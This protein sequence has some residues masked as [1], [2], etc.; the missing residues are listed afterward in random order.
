M[1]NSNEYKNN[2]D[3]LEE[4]LLKSRYSVRDPKTGKPLE[5]CYRDLLTNRLFSTLNDTLIASKEELFELYD[6]MLKRIIIPASPILM[7]L[8]NPHTRRHG[9]YSCYPLGYVQ[10]DM[11]SIEEIHRLMR[12]IYMSGG[13]VGIDLSKLRPMGSLVDNGQGI[14]SGPVGFLADFDAVT[15]TT[16]QGGRRRGALLVQMD[17]NHP[18]IKEFIKV[19]NI[20][21]KLNQYINTLP[22]D[23]RPVQGLQLSNMNI[24]V[25]AFGDFWND[26]NLI[27]LIA[28]NMWSTGDPGLLFIDNMLKNSPI[29]EEDNPRF[30]NPCVT[31]DTLVLTNKGQI[32]IIDLLDTPTV[33]WNGY[34]WSEVIPKQ[35]GSKQAILKIGF[36]NGAILKCTKYHKFPI[37]NNNIVVM[38]EAQNLSLGDKLKKFNYPVIYQESSQY[39]NFKDLYTRDAGM[40]V[41]ISFIEELSEVQDVYCFN[42]PKRHLGVFNGILTGQCGEFLSSANTACNLVTVN[43]GKIATHVFYG[44]K[45][46]ES[47]THHTLLDSYQSKVFRAGQLAAL[48]GNI[49]LAR[50]E[51]FPSPEIKEKTQQMRPVGVGMTGFHSALIAYDKGYSQ[52]GDLKSRNFAEI[53]QASLTLGTLFTSAKLAHKY[54]TGYEN[55]DY[56]RP[57]VKSLHDVYFSMGSPYNPLLDY[58]NRAVD[59][60]G[61]FYNC[62]TTSQPPTGSVSIF[63]HNMDTGIEPFFA[64][65]QERKIRDPEKGWVSFKQVSVPLEEQFAKDPGLRER[66]ESQTA[67]NLSPEA[68]LDMLASFQKYIHTGVSK[69]IN[70][71]AS[72]TVETIKQLILKAKDMNLKGFTVYRDTSLDGVLTAVSPPVSTPKNDESAPISSAQESQSKTTALFQNMD[73]ERDAVI[74]KAKSTSLNAHITLSHD[75][76]QNIREVFVAAGDLG[77][78]V[79][80]LFTAFGMIISVALRRSPEIFD[81]LVKVLCKV[82]M[83]QR[84]IIKTKMS[85]TPIVGNSLPQAIGLLMRLRKDFLT[86]GVPVPVSHALGGFDICPECQK[87]TLRREGSCK[88]CVEC[89]YSTC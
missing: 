36:S 81:D 56:W 69:T 52:Y 31:G 28:Q 41:T 15:G 33:V 10:D 42:E 4:Y 32:P 60:Y 55:E 49:I 58:I 29:K 13:G 51:G 57:H 61:G 43:V 22:V 39:E 35:T 34:E 3:I 6:L 53:T 76:S 68:Q 7:S 50:D 14:S 5:T 72:A 59:E 1:D 48:L 38:T 16:N 17:W 71:P 45:E 19:K 44:P 12:Q 78:D 86:Q 89:G 24:S 67:L 54:Q 9:Y 47:N 88:K 18:D 83:D 27:N 77:A 21:G 62:V 84:V 20:N 80:A 73:D 74:Y 8:G 75:T 87:L 85:A 37:I 63:A 30:S 79:N 65:S 82:N 25:N 11:R 66:V 23:E 70:L 40:F 26:D 2:W 46:E 64:L